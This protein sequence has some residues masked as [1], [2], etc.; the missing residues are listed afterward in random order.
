MRL[1]S[2]LT[3]G[4]SLSLAGLALAA[5]IDINVPR[6]T[7]EFRQKHPVAKRN[8]NCRKNF[9]PRSS[10]NSTDDVSDEFLEAIKK[11]NNGGTVYLPEGELFVIG[12][13]L[14]LTFLNDIHVRLE[15]TIQF[16][17]DVPFWQ[18]NAFYHPFQ[19]SLMF[20]KW[21]GKDVKIYG[22]GTLDGQ[23]QRWWNEFSGAEILDPDNAYLRPILFYA[24]HIENLYVEGILMKDSPV[25]HNFIV[26]SKNINYRDVIIEAKSNN[27]TVLPKNGDFFNSLNVER[28]RIE[29]VWVDSDDDCFSP[30][31]NNTDIHVNTMYCNNSHGQSLG[32]LGQYEGEYVF[33]K[34]VI[35][36]NVWM[37]NSDNGA[38]IKVWAGEHVATGFVDNI[39]FRNFYSANDAW[40]ISLDS[41]YFNIDAE[42]CNRFPS[43]MSV[44]NVLFENFTGISS[45]SK[46]RA[47]ARVSCST[48]AE[49]KCKNIK[50]KN[51]N[52]KSPCGEDAV[53]ICDGV[54]GDLGVPC[55]PFDSPEA[56][57][58][59]ADRCTGK[60][61]TIDAPWDVRDYGARG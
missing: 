11:A 19:R 35:I 57:A 53:V 4:T 31:S 54:E 30:K 44:S 50:F 49:G 38:R 29:R 24:E 17:N 40:P 46:G 13:P 48:N 20:W 32:S 47:V 7:Q 27:A 25:W 22:E 59:L 28:I 45:G 9:T 12:K 36:E 56:K 26:E 8:P 58:A 39:T 15:G 41:C 55:V 42:T 37:L 21:G 10:D 6:N 34:D 60:R 43:K 52:V 18:K 61:A 16:T 3:F 23:G 51:F 14:D 2:V 1:S 5:A 33:V